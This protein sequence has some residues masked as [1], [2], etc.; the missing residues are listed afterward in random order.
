MLSTLFGFLKKLIM[1]YCLNNEYTIQDYKDDI[2]TVLYDTKQSGY[3]L[4]FREPDCK[5]YENY[6]IHIAKQGDEEVIV[7][8]LI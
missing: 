3:K 4:I 6:N 8:D 2:N 7:I 5:S 1:E